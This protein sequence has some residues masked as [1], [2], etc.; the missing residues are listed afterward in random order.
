MIQI[1]DYKGKLSYTLIY[2]ELLETNPGM[3]YF[4]IF[5]IALNNTNG[6]FIVNFKTLRKRRMKFGMPTD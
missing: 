5:F 4:G 1:H 2:L 3:F 6:F